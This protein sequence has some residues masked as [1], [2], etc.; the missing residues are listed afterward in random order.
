MP[1]LEIFNMGVEEMVDKAQNA[2]APKITQSPPQTA[3]NRRVRVRR[4]KQS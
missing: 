4:S 2:P 3:K 1:E